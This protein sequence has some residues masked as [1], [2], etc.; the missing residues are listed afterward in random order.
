M[1]LDGLKETWQ[2]RVEPD[3]RLAK[4]KGD[5]MQD[6][7]TRLDRLD[8]EV[9]RRDIQEAAVGLALIGFNGW[10]AFTAQSVLARAGALLIAAGCAFVIL[11]SRR[12]ASRVGSRGPDAAASELPIVHFCRRELQFVDAQIRLLRSVWWWYV[13]PIVA[14]TELF[15]YGSAPQSPAMGVKMA[16]VLLVGVAIYWWNLDAAK[17]QLIPL[18]EELQRCLDEVNGGR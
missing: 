5:V 13:A 4:K 16:I 12:A 10:L 15:I 6:V 2:A 8:R 18:R 14:G 7:L 11:W 9:R 17:R 3:D 1:D